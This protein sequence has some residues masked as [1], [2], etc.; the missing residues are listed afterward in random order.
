MEEL[1]E[2]IKKHRDGVLLNLFV[3]S[4]A[5]SI[6]FPAGL[7]SWR[8]CIQI[9]VCSPA[10]DDKANKEVIKTVAEFFDKPVNDVFIVSGRRNR[11]KTLLIKGV[12]MDFVSDKLR[13][14]LDEL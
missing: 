4:E 7:D 1:K 14:S 10:K 12:P 5:K 6:M 2:I 3:T 13:G 8:K 9:K 11:E